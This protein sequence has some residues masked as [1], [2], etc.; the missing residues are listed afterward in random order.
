M[1]NKSSDYKQMKEAAI[2]RY[3]KMFGRQYKLFSLM[4]LF[5][6]ISK[7]NVFECIENEFNCVC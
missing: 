2:E 1:V 6:I 5:K 7:L 3:L 4:V